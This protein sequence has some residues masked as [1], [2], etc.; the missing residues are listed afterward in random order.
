[1]R[2]VNVYTHFQYNLSRYEIS[3]IQWSPHFNSLAAV[4]WNDVV[5]IFD[6]SQGFMRYV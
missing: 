1:M 4:A 3:W 2:F 5:E 6:P